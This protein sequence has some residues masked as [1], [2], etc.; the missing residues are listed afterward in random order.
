MRIAFSESANH[1]LQMRVNLAGLK[2]TLLTHVVDVR[3]V[4]KRPKSGAPSTR[5]MLC[6]NSSQL[7]NST[8]GRVTLNYKPPRGVKGVR[9]ENSNIAVTWDILMQDYRCINAAQCDLVTSVPVN[10]FWDY[11][12]THIG[13]MTPDEKVGYMNT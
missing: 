8:D 11:F 10:E 1:C 9:E 12:N 7:L 5:R 13:P 6:T 2:S 3:F 4:R